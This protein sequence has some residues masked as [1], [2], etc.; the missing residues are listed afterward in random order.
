MMSTH[1]VL[2]SHCTCLL[3]SNITM[4]GCFTTHHQ[5]DTISLYYIYTKYQTHSYT[6]KLD[7]RANWKEVNM[8]ESKN[9]IV[10]YTDISR[11]NP[12]QILKSRSIYS[13]DLCYIG[14]CYHR[15]YNPS[16]WQ[17]ASQKE[18]LDAWGWTFQ[19]GLNWIELATWGGHL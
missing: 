13:K 16:L 2:Q 6:V 11:M 7:S 3:V 14:L 1:R 10:W 5:T 9:R 17:G 12:Q 4:Y 18:D 19:L 15:A 8:E